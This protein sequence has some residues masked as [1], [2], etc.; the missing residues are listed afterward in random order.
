MKAAET[1]SGKPTD[2]ELGK[3]LRDY[4]KN[5]APIDVDFRALVPWLSYPE[6][7]THMVHSYPAKLLFH[8][9]YFLLNN[10]LL[11]RPGD[12]VLD[13]FCGT[14]TVLL[15][16]MLAERRGIGLDV[17]PLAVLV[18]RVKTRVIEGRKLE[19]GVERLLKRIPDAPRRELPQVINMAYWYYPHVARQLAQLREAVDSTR[20][21]LLRDFFAVCLSA[22]ARKTSLADPRVYV[23]VRLRDDQYPEGHPMRERT[24]RHLRRLK[25]V[26]V[27]KAFEGIL[28]ENS[29][30]MASLDC[31]LPGRGDAATYCCDV[32]GPG[33]ISG[34]LRDAG[35][36]SGKVGMVITSPPYPGAQKY[37]RATSLNLGWLGMCQDG[38]LRR[39]DERTIGREHYREAQFSASVQTGIPSLDGLLGDIREISPKR[40]HVVANYFTEMRLALTAIARGL[41][42]GGIIAMV[43]GDNQ[44]CGRAIENHRYLSEIMHSLG[45][46]T[47]LAL[48]NNIHSRGLMVKRNSTAAVIPEEWVMLFKKGQNA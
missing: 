1:V 38:E 19:A 23:P 18:A 28:S 12:T 22:C 21:P 5:E 30:R 32:R 3:L 34:C 20:C 39:L 31:L 24:L 6:R 9:P 44:V 27:H 47:I 29:K 17:N 33:S 40:A 10:D 16:S 43:V 4:E 2:R 15:E 26:N 7:T 46:G 37:M 14:G 25:R 35:V 42:S 36:H 48:R 8:I 11:S 45:F 41:R 13:P